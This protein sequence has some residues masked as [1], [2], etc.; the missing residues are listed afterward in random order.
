MLGLCSSCVETFMVQISPSVAIATGQKP[1]FFSQIS[2]Q[3]VLRNLF[4]WNFFLRN[5]EDI[6]NVSYDH[7]PDQ[8]LLVQER[9]NSEYGYST[10]QQGH[11]KK[12]YPETHVSCINELWWMIRP[13]IG[14]PTAPTNFFVSRMKSV[15]EAKTCV[16]RSNSPFCEKF[17]AAVYFFSNFR[18]F[19]LKFRVQFLWLNA[20]RMYFFDFWF[21][22]FFSFLNLF[23]KAPMFYASEVYIHCQISTV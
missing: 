21:S 3:L 17:C 1:N 9:W 4:F 20:P 10:K 6:S 7:V 8:F 5:I 14:P 22:P 16:F 11:L 23:P 2:L 13:R 19:E 12:F 15:S 18:N